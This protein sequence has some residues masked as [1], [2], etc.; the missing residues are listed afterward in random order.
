MS[1]KKQLSKYEMKKIMGGQE[2]PGGT[3]CNC[4]SNDDCKDSSKPT[5]YNGTA[6]KCTNKEGDSYAG[7]CDE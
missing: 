2:D 5:C 1:I 7:V 3:T 6:Y 4:N